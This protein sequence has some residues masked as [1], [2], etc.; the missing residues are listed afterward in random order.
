M[1]IGPPWH[2]DWWRFSGPAA[3]DV[4]SSCGHLRPALSL[5]SKGVLQLALGSSRECDGGT[6]AKANTRWCFESDKQKFNVSVKGLGRLLCPIKSSLGSVW[7]WQAHIQPLVSPK[8]RNKAVLGFPSGWELLLFM[9]N[10]LLFYPV[11]SVSPHVCFFFHWECVCGGTTYCLH[12][13]QC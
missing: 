13:S 5:N 2:Y 3:E 4:R 12:V 8:W 7:G 11:C 1:H 10:P 9:C 6:E